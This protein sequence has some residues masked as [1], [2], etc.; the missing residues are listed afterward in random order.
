M[1]IRTSLKATIVAGAALGALASAA[2][3]A[4]IIEQPRI[5]EAPVIEK[6]KPF[7][8]W[9]IRGDV[10]YAFVDER[11]GVDALDTLGVPKFGGSAPTVLPFDSDFDDGYTVGVGIGARLS[12]YLR[13]DITADYFGGSGVHFQQQTDPAC[14]GIA[15]APDVYEADLDAVIVMANAYV[16][17]GTY[18]GITPYVG[19]G[20]GFAHVEYDDVI[21]TCDACAAT[22]GA[23]QT[24][25]YDSDSSL[26]LAW[27]LSAGAS[28]DIN[29]QFAIDAG[30]K[31]TR[32][33][34]DVIANIE[35]TKFEDDGIDLHQIRVGARVNLH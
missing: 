23:T 7:G 6:V 33:Q 17:A 28:Y 26:R 12:Q 2:F 20:V 14:A 18:A 24:F 1:T 4:D 16:E 9:Y 29:D 13:A 15:C 34:D 19:A 3:A 22:G 10:G 30:Y 35:G 5:I 8:G 31:F 27:S 21:V 25:V 32:I 11:D